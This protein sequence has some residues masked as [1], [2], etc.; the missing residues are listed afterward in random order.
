[1]K[2][3]HALTE[4]SDARKCSDEQLMISLPNGM[5]NDL[6][7]FD[8]SKGILRDEDSNNYKILVE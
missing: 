2:R 1:M 5:L 7:S 6:D 8:K 3:V 4:D